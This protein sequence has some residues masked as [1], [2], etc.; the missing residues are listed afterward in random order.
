MKNAASFREFFFVNKKIIKQTL[1]TVTFVFFFCF[2]FLCFSF[3]TKQKFISSAFRYLN[4]KPSLFIIFF[5]YGLRAIILPSVTWLFRVLFII[6]SWTLR[7][8][9]IPRDFFQ[10]IFFFYNLKYNLNLSRSCFSY[11]FHMFVRSAL[12]SFRCFLFFARFSFLIKF[13][14]FYFIK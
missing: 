13:E 4:R 5:F 9:Y 14:K 1:I 2:F 11:F 6:F 7:F 8:G 12:K 3:P 10:S